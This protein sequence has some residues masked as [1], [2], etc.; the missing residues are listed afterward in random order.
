MR[1]SR[2]IAAGGGVGAI[3]AALAVWFVLL[4]PF[5]YAPPPGFEPPPSEPGPHAVFVY[6]TLRYPAIR[7]LVVGRAGEPRAAILPGFRRLHLNVE[8][9]PGDRVEGLVL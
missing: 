8:S 7:R 1:W 4:S 2:R 9:A 3:G 5:G 6:G